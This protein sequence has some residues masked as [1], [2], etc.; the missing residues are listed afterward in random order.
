MCAVREESA[1]NPF[2]RFEMT[3]ARRDRFVTF[4]VIALCLAGMAEVAYAV[5]GPD[6]DG[7]SDANR[8][9]MYQIDGNF[10]LIEI[11]SGTEVISD[12]A[13]VSASSDA[14]DWNGLNV[15][16]F[17]MMTSHTDNEQACNFL[18]NTE[19]DE[20][21]YNGGIDGS[22]VADSGLQQTLESEFYWIDSTLVGSTTTNS[23]STIASL[24]SGGDAG[25]GLYEFTINVV[26]NS[27]G[28]PV[29]QND[30]SDESI[31][32]TI[33]LITLDYTLTEV[34]E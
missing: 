8:V 26:V 33:S 32:W 30:D 2:G 15:V 7:D 1:S 16:G 22:T 19:D 3:E 11:G 5:Y 31:D 28:S 6:G 20:V 9:A 18:A 29:C 4:G 34:K 17:H 27:G 13:Q 12:S 10:S 23:T 14:V 25:M 24:L 21:G